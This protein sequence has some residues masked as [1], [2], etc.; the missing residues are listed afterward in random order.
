ML[1]LDMKRIVREQPLGYVATVAAD[2]TPNV[3]P[4]GTFFV[5]DDAT[6]AFAEIRSPATIRNLQGNPRIEVNFIDPF[7]RKGYRFA[8]TAKIVP[9]GEED[10]NKLLEMSGSTLAPRVR[11]VVVIT[12][13]KALPLVSPAYDDGTSEP[14]IRRSWTTRFRKLQPNERFEE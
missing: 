2:G 10:F 12:V 6:I 7:A 11:A 5:V 4:K 14:E 1:T 8:G 13:A 3:S 9:R